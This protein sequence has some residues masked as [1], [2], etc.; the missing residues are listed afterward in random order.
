MKKFTTLFALGLLT[1]LLGSGCATISKGRNEAVDI[2]SAPAG[3]TVVVN[4]R[5]VG[6]TPLKLNLSRRQGH[7]VNI[8]RPGYFSERIFLRTVPNEAATAFIRFGMDEQLGAHYDLTPKRID[9]ELDPLILPEEVGD[10]PISELALRVLDVD[11]MLYR[12][13]IT[14]DEHRYILSRLL[15]AYGQE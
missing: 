10:D 11:E 6:T 7:E 4:G 14:A 15:Q 1:S 12:G 3:A 2:T 5:A 9:V 8:E 13:E